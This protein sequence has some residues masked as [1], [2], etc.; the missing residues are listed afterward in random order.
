[1]LELHKPGL[2]LVPLT[3]YCSL[4]TQLGG[5]PGGICML[6]GRTAGVNAV[7]AC[8]GRELAAT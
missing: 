6:G 8:F 2:P 7:P 3:A 5:A 1:M 4:L